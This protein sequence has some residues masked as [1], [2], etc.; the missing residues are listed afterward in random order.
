MTRGSAERCL[1]P[2]FLF[3]LLLLLLLLRCLAAS[4]FFFVFFLFKSVCMTV[5]AS[6]VRTRES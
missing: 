5:Y 2:S 6:M 3:L 1:S 4:V